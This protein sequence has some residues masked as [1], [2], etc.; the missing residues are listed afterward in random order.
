[1]NRHSAASLIKTSEII[2]YI[3]HRTPFILV[4]ALYYC[5]SRRIVSSFEVKPDHLLVYQGYLQEAGIIEN[6]AQ[7][8]ALKSG[9]EADGGTGQ[10]PIG[11]IAAIKDVQILRLV[12][13][14]KTIITRAEVMVDLDSILV[15]K[16]ISCYE[17]FP[18]A[19]CEMRLF[20]EK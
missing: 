6:I 1:M 2:R 17:Q 13:I 20:L 9:Y 19:S 5:D 7:T 4:D 18:V 14:G 16:G 3:P 11:F 12:P 8:I 15:V 10:P